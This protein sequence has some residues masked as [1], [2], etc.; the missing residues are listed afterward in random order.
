MENLIHGYPA[1]KKATPDQIS[2]LKDLCSGIGVK[3]LA[4]F[5]IFAAMNN[6][7]TNGFEDLSFRDAGKL[8]SRCLINLRRY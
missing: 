6:V 2:I 1:E 3:N 7:K 5:I 8:I 4:G